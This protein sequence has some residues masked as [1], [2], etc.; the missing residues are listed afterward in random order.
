MASKKEKLN[1]AN[2]DENNV[3]Y[4]Q[5][6]VRRIFTGKENGKTVSKFE[7]LKVERP[8]VKIKPSEADVLNLGPKADVRNTIFSLYLLPGSEVSDF[9]HSEEKG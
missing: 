8:K 9:I 7:R 3:H 5:V 6:L 2:S 1:S 4:E